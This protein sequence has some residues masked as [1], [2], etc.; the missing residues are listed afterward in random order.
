MSMAQPPAPAIPHVPFLTMA[1]VNNLILF[2]FCF[3]SLQSLDQTIPHDFGTLHNWS[4]YQRARFC[5]FLICIHGES[6]FS[7]V[8]K[9]WQRTINIYSSR[10]LSTKEGPFRVQRNGR[11]R[12]RTGPAANLAYPSYDMLTWTRQCCQILYLQNLRTVSYQRPR[13]GKS[14]RSTS[15]H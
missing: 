14:S 7:L 3:Q 12:I 4:G 10:L 9:C 8:I 13:H 11:I 2:L 5:T 6:R 15:A 1:D